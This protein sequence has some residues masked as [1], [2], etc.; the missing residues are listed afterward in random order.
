M[1]DTVL[2]KLQASEQLMDLIVGVGGTQNY[3]A[4]VVLPAITTTAE[5]VKYRKGGNE[6]LVK[7]GSIN[8]L[9]PVGALPRETDVSFDTGTATLYE[10]AMRV[11]LDYR[12]EDAARAN[13]QSLLD[14]KMAKLAA[15]KNKVLID[16]EQAAA[17]L[18]FGS[19]NYTS[20]TSSAVDFGATGIRKTVLEAKDTVRKLAGFAPNTLVLGATAEIELRSNPDLQKIFDNAGNV[21]L[22]DVSDLARYFGVERVLVATATTQTAASAGDAGTGSYIWTADSAALIYSNN[23]A[24]SPWSPSFGY[25]FQMN[26]D[27]AGTELVAEWKNDPFITHLAYAQ[28]FAYVGTFVKAGYLWTNVDQG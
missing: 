12:E 3:I 18:V 8:A 7:E 24:P 16:K 4:D 11:G 23:N 9:R 5:T 28:R 17:D 13:P 22:P 6:H 27:G 26:Y 25:R 19:G 1:S 21:S 14:I 10:Y 20:R 15:A 2:D